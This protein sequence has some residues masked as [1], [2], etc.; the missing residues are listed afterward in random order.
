MGKKKSNK[1]KEVK[2]FVMEGLKEIAEEWKENGLEKISAN[3]HDLYFLQFKNG[4]NLDEILEHGHTYIGSHCM[5]LEKWSEDLN[6]LSKPKE[7][8]QIWFKLWNIHVH[9]YKVE[10][11]SHFTRLLGKSLYIDPITEGGEHLSFARISIKVNPSS[12]L[13]NN[14]TVVGK[15]GKS[16]IMGITY[17][18]RPDRCAF[19]NTFQHAN[20][21][22]AQSMK[23]EQKILKDQE[24]KNQE[25]EIRESESKEK[26]VEKEKEEETKEDSENEESN[27]IEEKILRGFLLKKRIKVAMKQ[28]MKK[29]KE[30]D[31]QT[32]QAVIHE[33]IEENT[34]NNQAEVDVTKVVVE[35]TI[36]EAEGSKDKNPKTDLEIQVENKSLSYAD[37]NSQTLVSI[38]N[39]DPNKW[40]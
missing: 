32:I 16:N 30:V 10:V 38:G 28:K 6:L 33:T 24:A 17:E 2:E 27:D 23:D 7:I 37:N 14:M 9:M 15:K 31:F 36:D 12:T 5:K 26:N 8:V 19:C 21:K 35:D 11:I 13:T 22:C 3:I 39:T 1:A 40:Y 18:W 4:S 29:M 34:Q 25:K 20:T